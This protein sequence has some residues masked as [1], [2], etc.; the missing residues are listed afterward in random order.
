MTRSPAPVTGAHPPSTLKRWGIA[1]LVVSVAAL[2]TTVVLGLWVPG[3][4]IG[5]GLLSYGL[6]VASDPAEDEETPRPDPLLH[7]PSASARA[8]RS[9]VRSRTAFGAGGRARDYFF[10]RQRT[11]ARLYGDEHDPLRGPDHDYH[12]D[13]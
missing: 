1:L 11:M 2:V 7:R 5:A 8:V 9:T 3:T 4:L 6:A 10:E 12:A 13:Y